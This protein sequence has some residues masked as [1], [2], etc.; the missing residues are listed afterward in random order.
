MDRSLDR[1]SLRQ[2]RLTINETTEKLDFIDI[3]KTLNPNK[4]EHTFFSSAHGTFSK[5][6]HTGAQN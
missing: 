1:K 5:I 6:D 4:P 3:F 2:Q